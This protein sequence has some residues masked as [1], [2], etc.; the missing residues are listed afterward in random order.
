MHMHRH[1][2]W[3]L[4]APP[5]G[6][7]RRY[8]TTHPCVSTVCSMSAALPI[9]F[10]SGTGNRGTHPS[11][12]TFVRTRCVSH[13]DGA[14]VAPRERAVSNK[15]GPGTSSALRNIKKKI[16]IFFFSFT[17]GGAWTAVTGRNSKCS[18]IP[19]VAGWCP[20]TLALVWI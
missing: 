14:R 3:R 4:Q 1:S 7:Q 19:E 2:C 6:N 12:N 9:L 13:R 18:N 20:G 17:V 15:A 10:S 16:N 5:P 8:K 11:A